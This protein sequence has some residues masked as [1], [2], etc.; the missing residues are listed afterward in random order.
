MLLIET[1]KCKECGFYEEGDG[2]GLVRC[3]NHYINDGKPFGEFNYYYNDVLNCNCECR[4]FA[5]GKNLGE[6]I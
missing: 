6:A 1:E 3:R 5:I 2:D 4:F